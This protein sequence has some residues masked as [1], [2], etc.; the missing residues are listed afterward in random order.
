MK[1][2][3]VILAEGFEEVEAITPVDYLRRA[4]VEVTVAGLGARRVMGGHGITVEADL[5]LSEAAGDFD[6]VIVPGGA[7]GAANLA[8]SPEAASFIKRHFSAGRLVAAICAAPAV[9]LHGACGILAGRR[10]T[11]Y[12][13]TE[14][15][16]SGAF[17]VPD[18]VVLDGNLLTSRAA[19]TAG[20]FARA[21]VSLLLGEEAASEVAAKVLLAEDSTPDRESAAE[22]EHYR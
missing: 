11:G 19:G 6:A 16:V 2:A 21:L 13:G 18:A 8:A 10:F 17:F 7:K 3:C 22:A 20:R 1:R 5:S 12:P 9:V 15:Q 14:S 4:G